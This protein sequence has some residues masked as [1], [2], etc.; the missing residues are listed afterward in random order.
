MDLWANRDQAE[1]KVS[2]L[3]KHLD[4]EVALLHLER[5]GAKLTPLST[6]QADYIGVDVQGPYKPEAYRY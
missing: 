3:P 5:I 6:D 1:I 2:I 4:E